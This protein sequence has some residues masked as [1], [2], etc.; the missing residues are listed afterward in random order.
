MNSG[1][2]VVIAY[3]EEKGCPGFRYLCVFERNAETPNDA[4]RAV[5]RYVSEN[6]GRYRKD[7][8][9]PIKAEDMTFHTI[10]GMAMVSPMQ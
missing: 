4:V 1:F 8:G 9:E 7:N 5:R 10:P 2:T 6:P 3:P